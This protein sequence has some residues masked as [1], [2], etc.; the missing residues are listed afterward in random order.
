M[1]TSDS[2]AADKGHAN[3]Q[4]NLGYS[5]DVGQGVPQDYSEAVKWYRLAAEQGRCLPAADFSRL[6]L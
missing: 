3:A 5:Y 4:H 2:L 1:L 6:H